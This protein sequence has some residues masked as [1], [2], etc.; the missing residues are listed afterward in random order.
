M[1]MSRKLLNFMVSIVLALVFCDITM[2]EPISLW[3]FEYTS[4]NY[5]SSGGTVPDHLSSNDGINYGTKEWAGP[6]EGGT[7]MCANSDIWSRFQAGT[8][9]FDVNSGTF[10]WA[11]RKNSYTRNAWCDMFTMPLTEDSTNGIRLEHIGSDVFTFYAGPSNL[12]RSVDFSSLNVMDGNWHTIAITYDDGSPIKLYIDGIQELE[13]DIYDACD[14]TLMSSVVLGNRTTANSLAGDY[15]YFIYDTQCCTAYQI[16]Q[17]HE[18]GY[19]FGPAES[20]D[21]NEPQWALTQNSNDVNLISLWHFNDNNSSDPNH[22]NDISVPDQIG[23]NDGWIDSDATLETYYAFEGDHFMSMDANTAYGFYTTS[24]TGFSKYAGTFIFGFKDNGSSHSDWTNIIGTHLYPIGLNSDVNPLR[25]EYWSDGGGSMR[26][27]GNISC[28]IETIS[29]TNLFDGNWHICVLT[30]A[31]GDIVR[32]YVDGNVFLGTTVPYQADNYSIRNKFYLGDRSGSEAFPADYDYLAYYDRQFSEDEVKCHFEQG[33]GECNEVFP[34]PSG[35]TGIWDRSFYMNEL[36]ATLHLTLE[37]VDSNGTEVKCELREVNEPNVLETIITNIDGNGYG[38]AV[39]DVNSL[40]CVQY[41]VTVSSNSEPN[42]N[43]VKLTNLLKKMAYKTNAVQYN[44]RGILIRNGEPL[45]PFGVYYVQPYI[46]DPNDPN[47]ILEEYGAA[48]FN[49]HN[50]EWGNSS[51]YIQQSNT[52]RSSGIRPILGIQ[53]STE[54]QS[55]PYNKWNEARTLS[56]WKAA[57][58]TLIDDVASSDGN[59]ILAWYTWD[60]PPLGFW[61]EVAKTLNDVVHANDPYR[62][63]MT[64]SQKPAIYSNIANGTDILG[65]DPYPYFYTN[66]APYRP[67]EIV[68]DWT[69]SAVHA[70]RGTGKPIL[71]A[72]QSFYEGS[73][74]RMPNSDELRCMTYLSVVHGATGIMYF[75]FDYNGRMDL[76]SPTTWSA[77]KD[78]AGEMDTIESA[79]VS[80]LPDASLI[81]IADANT[82]DVKLFKDANEYYFIAVNYDDSNCLGVDFTLID[83]NAVCADVLFEDRTVNINNG[84]WMDDFAPYAVHIYKFTN[85]LFAD[86]F[87]TSF[88]KWTDGGASDWDRTTSY[89]YSGSYSAHAGSTDN[90]LISDN[91]NTSGHGSMTISFWYRD[92]DIDD[93]D[94]IYLQL[95]DGSAYDN[96]FEL[97]NT[98]PEDTWHKYEVT[99]YNAGSDAQYFIS[100]FRLKFE[101]TS[102]DSGENLWIDNVSIIVQN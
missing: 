55:I 101:G 30:Y 91:I 1:F 44:H 37:F 90:D 4:G 5:G 62:P 48:E 78:L 84:T 53:N 29:N 54:I 59:D 23:S 87:E 96:K 49:T 83:I 15:D 43:S 22:N 18:N 85:A 99:L 67:V 72:L 38:E 75:S 77:L 92:D 57:A 40:D 89:K 13:T 98:S 6:Y 52:Q 14:Y 68:A 95:Y 17:A 32:F 63:S 58:E 100:N 12:G 69:D 81:S 35:I 71:A 16:A 27:Y 46:D 3:D 45:F 102:I 42:F 26:I 70:I 73:N 97:G 24:V 60:E 34:V 39:F 65:I 56:R 8:A 66:S 51:Y 61:Y 79:L 80:D 94:N 25:V 21:L 88:D 19:L 76:N 10:M 82:V 74:G 41:E 86:D 47:D 28:E 93:D 36:D 2:G 50:L 33:I 11:Y 20:P 31:D 64:V 7:F 9:N